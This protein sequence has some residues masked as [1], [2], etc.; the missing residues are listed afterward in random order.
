MHVLRPF[1][2]SIPLAINKLIA[3]FSFF[4][5]YDFPSPLLHRRNSHEHIFHLE[6]E[7]PVF[8]SHL[9]DE[10]ELEEIVNDFLFHSTEI[11][12]KEFKNK[13]FHER[14]VILCVYPLPIIQFPVLWKSK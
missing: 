9:I 14:K 4:L 8:I 3:S 11:A 6:V 1:C 7:T 13:M 2:F 10:N 12:F 5:K